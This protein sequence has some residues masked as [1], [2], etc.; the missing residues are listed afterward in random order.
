MGKRNDNKLWRGA[1]A[2]L[3]LIILAT[4]CVTAFAQENTAEGWYKKG[5]E[6]IGKAPWWDVIK[7]YDRAT[8]INP[9]NATYW[10]AKGSA[11]SFLALTTNN[12]SKYN[13]SLEA[14]KKAVQ[15]DPTNP[16]TWD[17]MGSTL[18]QMK[19][20]NESL[21]A[22]DRAIEQIN[23]YHGNLPVTKTE[24]LSSIWA[25][26]AVTLQEA[27]KMAESLAA[28]DKALQIDPGN[29]DAYMMKGRVLKAMDKSIQAYNKTNGL[30]Y[31]AST[32][33]QEN[34]TDQLIKKGYEL[35]ENGSYK[36]AI[37][38]FDIAIGLMPANDTKSLAIAWEG[39]ALALHYMGNNFSDMARDR[40]EMALQSY[41][42][43]IVLDPSFTGREAQLNKAGVL[44]EMGRYNNSSEILDKVI[45][46]IPANDTIYAS[47]VWTD[48]GS[49]L[50][51]M[52][53]YDEALR[54]C[55]AIT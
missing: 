40:Y 9:N 6:M 44:S 46:T 24:M 11:F 10:A 36:Q 17:K 29:Y 50:E 22:R 37:Q 48:K 51:K 30:G 43:A 49:V 35:S 31:N 52:D 45:Q 13:E 41:E 15:L 19:K 16:W 38:A 54:A 8:Q 2:A 20:Y 32:V 55:C 23:E 33:A 7:A 1:K 25:G 27:G 53:K 42:R 28:F 12:Q 34:T 39:K 26:K 3:I 47:V 14:Y 5:Q 18:L 21:E 4:L